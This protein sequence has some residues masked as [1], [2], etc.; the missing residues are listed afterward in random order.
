MLRR[1][2]HGG[3]T[4]VATQAPRPGTTG[5]VWMKSVPHLSSHDGPRRVQLE[6]F[7]PAR[8]RKVV[9]SNPTSGP[10]SAAER[11]SSKA[12]TFGLDQVVAT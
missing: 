1:T 10:I 7:G 8:N 4:S 11:L 12:S 9:G 5:R 6:G 2:Q 3:N